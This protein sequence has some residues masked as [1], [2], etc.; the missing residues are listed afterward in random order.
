[1][2]RLAAHHLGDVHHSRCFRHLLCP[3]L[4]AA[5]LHADLLIRLLGTGFFIPE[6]LVA[7]N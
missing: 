1:M 3:Y 7:N 5:E 2:F 6:G 4:T